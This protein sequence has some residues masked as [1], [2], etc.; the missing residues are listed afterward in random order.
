MVTIIDPH[1]KREAGYHIHKV[2]TL[3]YSILISSLYCSPIVNTCKFGIS[4][5]AKHTCTC[6][7]TWC[8]S[9]KYSYSMLVIQGA[10]TME[11]IRL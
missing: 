5:Y 3:A 11:L 4:Y 2:S 8:H 1:I 7:V 10:C 6:I 9:K